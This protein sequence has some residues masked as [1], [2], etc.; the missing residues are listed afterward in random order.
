MP[1]TTREFA[2]LAESMEHELKCVFFLV[3][4]AEHPSFPSTKRRHPRRDAPLSL[5]SRAT[6][7]RTPNL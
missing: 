4:N 3:P 2:Q 6:L 7:T 5:S 1:S